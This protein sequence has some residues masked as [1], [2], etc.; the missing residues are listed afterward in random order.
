MIRGDVGA[1]RW[2]YSEYYYFG[3]PGA[4][5]T[6]GYALS[7]AGWFPPQSYQHPFESP[8]GNIEQFLPAAIVLGAAVSTFVITAVVVFAPFQ[9]WMALFTA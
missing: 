5:Y 9:H 3:N 8:M 4:Y 2:G 1:R 7:D 6:Y